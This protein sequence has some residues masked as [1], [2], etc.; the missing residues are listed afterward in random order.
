MGRT[1]FGLYQP[2]IEDR[3]VR[4][5]YQLKTRLNE[6]SGQKVPMTLVLNRIL[7]RFFETNLE[8]GAQAPTWI[9]DATEPRG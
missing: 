9:A 1:R 5:L 3:N 8:A 2:F 6:A 7:D 4:R